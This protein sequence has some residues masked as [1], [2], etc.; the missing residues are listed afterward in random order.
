MKNIK[1]SLELLKDFVK[2]IQSSEMISLENANERVLAFDI[3]ARFD[4]PAFDNTALDG[5]AFAYEDRFLPLEIKGTILA[6]DSKER[7]IKSAE[8]FKIMTGAKLPKGADTI[9][10]LEDEAFKDG[11]LIIEVDVNRHNAVRFKA[12]ELK[13]GD[14]LFKKHSCLKPAMIALLASQGIYKIP[15]LRQPRVGVFASGDELREPWEHCEKEG[16]IYNANAFGTMA[17]LKGAKLS[18]L[19]IIED[20]LQACKDALSCKDYDLFITS[21]AA[22]AGEADFFKQ[23]LSELGFKAV[24][25]G[26]KMKPGKPI[27]LFEKDGILVLVLPGNPLPAYLSTAIFAREILRLLS[28]AP[29]IKPVKAKVKGALRLRPGRDNIIL[30]RLEDGFFLPLEQKIG[31]AFLIPLLQN[32]HFCVLCEEESEVLVYSL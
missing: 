15:V 20:K 3:K 6:G 2:P 24:F 8:C 1:D 30:G 14:L 7:E 16:L 27:K 17:L 28:N 13:S 31:M 12:E 22:S 23:A 21:G 9:I 5:Y 10:R 29:V 32:Q 26:V 11:K 19:G 18:Y 4:L 25:D